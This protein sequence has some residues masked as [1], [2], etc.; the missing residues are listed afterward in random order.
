M[1]GY[2]LTRAA[3][4]DLAGLYR[5]GVTTFG[6]ARADRYFDSLVAELERIA[7]H[8]GMYQRSE[9]RDG[10][11]RAAHPPHTIYFRALEDGAVLVVRIL[12]GQDPREA[13]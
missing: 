11:R 13:L 1:A 2:K 12:Y 7:A 5:H 10:Y 9:Y 6:A 4:A 8:P 3:D